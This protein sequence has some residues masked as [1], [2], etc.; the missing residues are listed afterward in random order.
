M[1]SKLDHF[2]IS[3]A[4]ESFG[5]TEE[6]EDATSIFETIAI[7]AIRMVE[8]CGPQ[9]DVIMRSKGVAR[10]EILEFDLGLENIHRYRK[11]RRAHKR[12]HDPFNAVRRLSIS[13]PDSHTKVF[14]K[15][16]REKRQAGNVVEMTVRDENIY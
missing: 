12:A 2:G 14:A 7:G 15:E 11:P 8:Q 6:G 16:G 1:A 4:R 5:V 13:C 3:F 9:R 10:F